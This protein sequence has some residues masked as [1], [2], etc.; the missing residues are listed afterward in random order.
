M[1]KYL[2]NLTT[3]EKSL[4]CWKILNEFGVQSQSHYC[5]LHTGSLQLS[6]T[7]ML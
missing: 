7:I 6:C 1:I 5:R 4:L 2:N 3:E